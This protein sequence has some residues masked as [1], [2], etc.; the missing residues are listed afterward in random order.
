MGGILLGN[1]YKKWLIL[2]K[3]RRKFR[4]CVHLDTCM[5]KAKFG[6]MM[7][8]KGPGGQAEKISAPPPNDTFCIPDCVG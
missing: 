1:L 5:D 6:K 2:D 8:V 7:P 4:F 3:N